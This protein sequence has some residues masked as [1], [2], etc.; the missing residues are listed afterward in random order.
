M[1]ACLGGPHV[2]TGSLSEGSRS[3]GV[4]ESLEGA[5]RGAEGEAEAVGRGKQ[6][7]SGQWTGP[8]HE[9][10]PEPPRGTGPADSS[11]LACKTHFGFPAS[12]G[13]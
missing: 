9:G 1:L 10:S 7:A 6:A 4:K 12:G 11:V 8:G 5:R 13:W 3:G 2:V